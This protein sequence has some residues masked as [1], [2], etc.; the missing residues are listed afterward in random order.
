VASKK[1]KTPLTVEHD[2]Q[3]T[4]SVYDFLYYDA[5]RIASFLSQFDT[6]GHLTE[7]IQ[8][9]R[10]HRNRQTNTTLKTGG[11]VAVFSGTA[12]RETDVGAEYGKESQRTYDPRWANALTFLDYLDERELIHR[13]VQTARIGQISAVLR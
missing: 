12:A 1:L 3:N 2:E 10:A 11:P 4:G 13:D 5:S 6:S 9:E 7:V 8:G